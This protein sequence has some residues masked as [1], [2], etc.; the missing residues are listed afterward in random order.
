MNHH[1]SCE[2]IKSRGLNYHQFQDFLKSSDADYE[3]VICFSEVM[4]LSQ[5]KMFKR[6]CDLQNET[7]SFMESS[8]KLVPE[9]E[10]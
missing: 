8:W 2:L 1:Q 3:D 5:G 7:K 9:H 10:D 6:F 4:C